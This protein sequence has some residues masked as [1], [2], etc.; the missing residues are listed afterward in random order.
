MPEMVHLR[1]TLQDWMISRTKSFRKSRGVAQ[2]AGTADSLDFTP[3]A[4]LTSELRPDHLTYGR[5]SEGASDAVF[6]ICPTDRVFTICLTTVGEI[7]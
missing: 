7:S 2:A 5:G 1:M 4:E 6:R 3:V